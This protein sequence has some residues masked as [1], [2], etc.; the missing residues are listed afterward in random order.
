MGLIQTIRENIKEKFLS[1]IRFLKEAKIELKKVTW[2]S[3]KD[4][5][6]STY[7]VIIVVF[8]IAIFLGLVD[9]GLSRILKLLLG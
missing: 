1:L 8:L 5:L 7:V 2:P 9:F 6:G 4:T 3:K